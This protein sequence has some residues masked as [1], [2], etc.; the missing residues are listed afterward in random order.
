MAKEPKTY[1][2]VQCLKPLQ[3]VDLMEFFTQ[4][5][6]RNRTDGSR[7]PAVAWNHYQ[8]DTPVANPEQGDYTVSFEFEGEPC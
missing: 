2:E 8:S 3:A 7:K 6:A 4:S 5:S 1:I